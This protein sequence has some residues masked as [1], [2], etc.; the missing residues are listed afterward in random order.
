MSEAREQILGTL[1]RN[2]KRGPLEGKAKTDL[3][4]RLAH[5]PSQPIPARAQLSHPEQV[6]LFVKMATEAS[7]SV[8]RVS[9]LTHVPNAVASFVAAHELPTEIVVT[10]DPTLTDL[11]WSD[12]EPTLSVE[13]RRAEDGDRVTVSLAFSGMAET[14]TLM[15]LSGPRSPITLN[16]LP[17]AHIVV[18]PV[19][20]I[21]GPY[22]DAWNLLRESGESM[23][24]AVNWITGP[25]RSADIEQQL[26]MGAHGP[27]QLHILLLEESL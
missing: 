11:S 27:I 12:T 20:R 19:Q 4:A 23:P 22:E 14:G 8:E 5:P 3:E 26:Q 21:V 9:G 16:F 15:M 1:R 10:P 25:S 2:L 18:L 13:N 24:R 7:A 17:D 6:E